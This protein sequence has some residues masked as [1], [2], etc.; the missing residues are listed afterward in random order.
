MDDRTDRWRDRGSA[1]SLRPWPYAGGLAAACFAI[2]ALTGV[3]MAFSYQPTPEHAYVTSYYISNVLPYGWL[4]RT[5]HAWAANLMILFA[6]VHAVQVF[7]SGSY[8][9]GRE[10]NWYIGIAAFVVTGT[11]AFT[12]SLLPWDQIAYWSTDA[13]VS[14]LAQTPVL[15]RALAGLMLGGQAVGENALT[16]FHAAHV[17]L[18]PA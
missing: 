18:L 14:I 11:A 4:V 7:I 17:T 1:W 10:A 8:K 12:G 15:G 2:L 5:V 3:V 16:R 9:G 13:G 6:A